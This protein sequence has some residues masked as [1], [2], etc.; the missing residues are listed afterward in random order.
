MQISL[1]YNFSIKFEINKTLI[2]ARN[3]SN[4]V[5]NVFVTHY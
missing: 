3:D 2:T 5:I 1:Q 4:I